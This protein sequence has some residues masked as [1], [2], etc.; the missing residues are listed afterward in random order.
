MRAL[1]FLI[2]VLFCPRLGAAEDTA[3]GEPGGAREAKDLNAEE[4]AA[5]AI[6]EFQA[7]RYEQAA[8]RFLAAFRLSGRPSPLRNAAKALQKAELLDRSLEQWK[9]YMYLPGVTADERAEAEANI[10]LIKERQHARAMQEA[11]ATALADAAAARA[12]AAQLAWAS[13]E[14]A[15]AASNLAA[16]APSAVVEVPPA[17]SPS[18]WAYTL[19]GAG[20]LTTTIGA[21]LV[22]ASTVQLGQVDDR[23]GEVDS[24]GKISGIGPEELEVEV[25]SINDQRAVA[26]VLLLAGSA[27]LT[28]GLVWLFS[29]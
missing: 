17:E 2:A 13:S 16:Q 14:E 28:G 29:D 27:V 18:V 10:A 6:A 1:L 8:E 20:G 19:V 15:R 22:I 24:L 5:K 11:A 23:L 25:G 26:R 4:E 9:L 7:G 21:A 3:E 12:E